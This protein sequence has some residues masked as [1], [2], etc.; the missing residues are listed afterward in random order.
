MKT[1]C[2]LA[3]SMFSLSVSAYAEGLTAGEKKS[4]QQ[5]IQHF[6]QQN[7]P[8]ITQAIEY[9][10]AREAP[11]A[12]IKNSQEM[13]KRFEQVFDQKIQK[14]IAQ[15]TL[16]DWDRMG[17]RGIMFDQGEIWVDYDPDAKTVPLKIRTVNYSSD[18]EQK[19]RQQVL[20]QQKKS[21]HPSIQDFA[22]PKLLFK[23]ATHLIRIDELKNGQMRYAAW[24]NHQDQSKKPDL[25]LNRGSYTTEGSAHNEIYT[26][27]SGPYTYIAYNDRIGGESD[28][29]LSLVVTNKDKQILKQEGQLL[30]E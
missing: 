21:L 22:E 14:R 19:L 30:D 25:V 15:S 9:P 27:K 13:Q 18:A 16:N 4:I 3:L 12:P 8:T 6:K 28:S 1:V 11:L 5:L 29:P 24:K 17:W 26:F 10:L 2:V 7:I 23:T 20:V